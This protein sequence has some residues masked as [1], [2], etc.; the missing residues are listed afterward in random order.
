MAAKQLEGVTGGRLTLQESK[1]WGVADFMQELKKVLP[2]H[3]INDLSG[4]RQP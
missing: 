4:L 3:P 2:R 1:G